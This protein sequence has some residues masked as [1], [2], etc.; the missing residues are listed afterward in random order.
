MWPTPAF[1]FKGMYDQIWQK[2][3]DHSK[4]RNALPFQQLPDWKF[5]VLLHELNFISDFNYSRVN[6]S[7]PKHWSIEKFIDQ[8][9]VFDVDDFCDQWNCM[10]EVLALKERYPNFKCTLFTIPNKISPT[11]LA[12]A[13]K[14]DWIELAVHGLNHEPLNETIYLTPGQLYDGLKNIDYT[15]YAK[16]YRP[17]G[18]YI[19]E[20]AIRVCK[21][22]GLWVAIHNRDKGMVS[23]CENYQCG[24]HFP[25]WHGHTHNVCDNWIKTHLNSLLVKW[26]TNQKFAFVSEAT[27]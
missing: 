7:V 14:H 19:N 4:V 21:E 1:I 10:E 27:C 12:E 16:G 22:L 13:K 17:P 25:Y 18:W 15:T 26:P 23:N 11:L 3:G 24:S 20:Q 9:V 6:Q 8:P 2:I 5:T